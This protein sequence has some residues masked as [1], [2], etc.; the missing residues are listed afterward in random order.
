MTFFVILSTLIVDHHSQTVEFEWWHCYNTMS[1][2]K[3]IFRIM[4]TFF[5]DLH[6]MLQQIQ[7]M[8]SALFTPS[9]GNLFRSLNQ[10]S[11]RIQS[12]QESQNIANSRMARQI[13]SLRRDVQIMRRSRTDGSPSSENDT[14]VFI[15]PVAGVV[16]A[17]TAA[18]EIA[19][20]ADN[21][22]TNTM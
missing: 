8:M 11:E 14:V 19:G 16:N 21:E 22:E 6:Q 10:I 3:I 7:A 1:S 13:M 4:L 20:Q 9:F 15:P 5:I 2:S 12:I 18:N 17:P